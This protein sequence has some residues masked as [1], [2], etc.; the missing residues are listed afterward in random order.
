MNYLRII[1]IL[2]GSIPDFNEL[3]MRGFGGLAANRAGFF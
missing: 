3:V 1:V 2:F